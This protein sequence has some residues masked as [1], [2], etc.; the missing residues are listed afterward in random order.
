MIYIINLYKSKIIPM[1][2]IS[3]NEQ[4]IIYEIIN[5]ANISLIIINYLSFNNKNIWKRVEY[6]Y[7][8][9]Y[10]YIPKS[11]DLKE[12]ENK[13]LKLNGSFINKMKDT[14]LFRINKYF[15]V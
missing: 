2:Y 11:F 12:L 1:N 9:Y 15:N 5:N 4:D 6:K 10:V 3:I 8:P 13:I 14:A 7:E